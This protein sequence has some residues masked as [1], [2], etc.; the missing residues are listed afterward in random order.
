MEPQYGKN[1]L[2]PHGHSPL[3]FASFWVSMLME[4]SAAKPLSPKPLV[5]CT[6]IPIFVEIPDAA[7]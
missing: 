4:K 6:G 3:L 1:M 2:K 7:W 5:Q